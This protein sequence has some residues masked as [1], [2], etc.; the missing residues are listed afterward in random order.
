MNKFDIRFREPESLE[1]WAGES[2]AWLVDAG[3]LVG[4]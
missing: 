2:E 3:E 4:A 1:R